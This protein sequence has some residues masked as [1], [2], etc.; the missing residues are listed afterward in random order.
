[1]TDE[2]SGA[3]TDVRRLRARAGPLHRRRAVRR[4][5]GAH[6]AVAAD[7]SLVTVAALTTE[8]QHRAARPSTCGFA[9]DN[10]VTEDE[11]IEAI[12]HLAFYA[13]WPKAMSAMAVA[14]QVFRGRLRPPRP[15]RKE[16]HIMRGAVLHAPGDVRVEER[17]DPTI[18]QARPTRSSG[19]SATCVCGS[20][21]WPYRG[22]DDVTR[23]D[24]DGP[25]V[26]RHRRG[27]RQRGH[28]RCSPASSSSARSSPPT[29]PARSAG[30]ATRPTACTPSSWAPSAPRPSCSGSRSPTAPW[31]PPPSC[32]TTTWSRA[33]WPP[34]TCWA[35]AGSPPS[36]PTSGPAR[37][38][39]SSA[40]ARSA[41]SACWPPSSSAPSGSS[42]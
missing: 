23:P 30:P 35:P 34:P 17:A 40:T 13:G 1:M 14:K 36:A 16:I 28:A 32:P 25:R 5:V 18:E 8:R 20:D 31:W 10:G 38:S 9:K 21:L 24:P 33:C 7:R 39:R 4:G 2:P 37:P 27:G 15:H 19:L 42:R 12:T 26:R 11:L 41:C 3:E 29:T 6:R 22:I